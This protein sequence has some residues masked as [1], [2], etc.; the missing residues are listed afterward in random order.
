MTNS[1]KFAVTLALALAAIAAVAADGLK[2]SSSPDAAALPYSTKPGKETPVRA[3]KGD[4]LR[5]NHE[6]RQI[7]GVT[8]VLRDFDRIVR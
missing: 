1:T 4:R 6:I 2:S 7:A 5:V 3:T 8:V